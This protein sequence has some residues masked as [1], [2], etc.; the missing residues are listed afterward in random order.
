MGISLGSAWTI[1]RDLQQFPYKIQV[2]QQLTVAAVEKRMTFA[3][4]MCELVDQK[5]IDLNKIVF[6]DEAHFWLNGYENKQNYRIWGTEK[7]ELF[8]TK[9]LKPLKLTVWCGITGAGIIGPFFIEQS[10]NGEEYHKMLKENVL[11]ADK[12]KKWIR[13]YHFQ[14]DGA[15]PHITDRNLNLLRDN[16]G[17][18]VI[19]RRFPDVFNEG[20]HWPPI[21]ETLH[22]ATSSCGD[23]QRTESIVTVLGH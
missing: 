20:M 13:G 18:N 8:R 10:I 2:L 22:H 3:S 15:P 5:S 9:P 11:P 21:A 17:S 6:T 7:P 23:S 19:S 16:Y 14:Q 4:E 1:L 12:S